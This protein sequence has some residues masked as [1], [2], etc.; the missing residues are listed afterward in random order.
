MS[1]AAPPA[2]P[3]IE[4][5]IDTTRLRP[6]AQRSPGVIAVVGTGTKG[7]ENVPTE[8]STS[9]DAS[10][11]GATST[12]RASLELAMAQ[13]PKPSKIYG[14]RASTNAAGDP[15]YATALDSLAGADDVTFVALASEPNPGNAGA[16]LLA[17]LA[18]VENTSKEGNKRIGF[19]EVDPATA[20]SASYVADTVTKYDPIKSTVSRM[21]LVAARGAKDTSTGN[22]ADVATAAMAALAGYQPQ[23]SPVLKPIRGL[24]IATQD[25]YTP[26]EIKGLSTANI[27]PI[28]DPALIPG[29]G[30]FFGEARTFTSDTD[31]LY[32]D[33]VRTLDQVEFALKAGLIG[34]VGDAR[35]TKAGMMSVQLQTEAILG[36]MA[37]NE[38]IAGFRVQIPVLD[39]LSIPEATRT[40]PEKEIVRQARQTRSVEMTVQIEYGP[41]VHY[42]LV[43][44]AAGFGT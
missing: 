18:H 36:V 15:D 37:R 23:I 11:F 34:S 25:K 19:A 28:I 8:I 13:N 29:D 33:V 21:V 35:I 43:H 44:L 5:Q 14:V 12:L 30:L 9:D 20:K 1:V 32:V 16:K 40:P 22:D 10:G 24:R 3:F 7:D 26:S 4:V 42:L 17:L 38:M 39:V 41:A 27:I 31:L 2:F 6:V